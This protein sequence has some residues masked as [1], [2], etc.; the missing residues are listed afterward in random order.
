LTTVHFG[1]LSVAA[2]RA[3]VKAPQV[4]FVRELFLGGD[5]GHVEEF[6]PGPDIPDDADEDEAA[7]HVLLRWP[8]LRNI[9]RFQLGWLANEEYG[10]FCHFQCHLGGRLLDDF[11]KQMPNVEELLVFAHFDDIEK[12]VARPMPRLRV[13]QLYHGWSYPLERLARNATLTKLTHLLCH[14]HALDYGAQPYISLADLRAVCRSQHLT[15]LTHLRLRLTNFGDDGAKVIVESGIL[16]RLKVLDLRHGAIT[17]RGAGLLAAC[18]DLRNLE[19]LDLS[20]NA[21]TE[22]GIAALRT[23]TI[24]V[25]LD[26]QHAADAEET[27]QREYL[28]EG[29]YE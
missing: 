20:R 8:H 21:L 1:A 10:D 19:L 5:W 16:K 14:P 15:S 2:A 6:E 11:V 4:R 28:F 13:L 26:H 22:V 27:G 18:P 23:T 12:L 29:D 9:R 3:F 7:L 17:D 25:Q 24:P